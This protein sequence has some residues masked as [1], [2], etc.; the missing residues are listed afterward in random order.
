MGLIFTQQNIL[1]ARSGGTNQITPVVNFDATEIG[2]LRATVLAS[3][4]VRAKYGTSSLPN[5]TVTVG[6]TWGEPSPPRFLRIVVND[7]GRQLGVGVGDRIGY[8]VRYRH[9][10]AFVLTVGVAIRVSA[11]IALCEHVYNCRVLC[12]TIVHAV[13]DCIRGGGE[14]SVTAHQRGGAAWQ[15]SCVRVVAVPGGCWR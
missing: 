11:T 15:R 10:Y 8:R 2:V 9:N 7:T 5:T 4:N 3:A 14:H 12:V 13:G 6:G 1:N